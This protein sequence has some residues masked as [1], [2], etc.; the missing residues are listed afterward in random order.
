MSNDTGLHESLASQKVL[1]AGN[2]L[3]FD[4][5]VFVVSKYFFLKEDQDPVLKLDYKDAFKLS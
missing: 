5:E 4:P 1:I 3:E 2:L